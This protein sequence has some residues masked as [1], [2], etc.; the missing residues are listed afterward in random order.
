MWLFTP[1]GF[2]SI[3]QK[4]GTTFLTIRARVAKDLDKWRERYLPDVSDATAGGG[5]DYP[6]RAA[7]DQQAFA[8]ALASIARDIDYD[9]FKSE[10]ARRQGHRRAAAY[11]E[12]WG[13]LL[14]LERDV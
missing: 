4:P 12:V 6:S 1:F 8:Q 9:N 14:D 10:V 5:T 2:F 13:A 7:V 3:V 11:S